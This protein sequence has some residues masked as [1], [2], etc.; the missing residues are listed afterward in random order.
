MNEKKK[1]LTLEFRASE[2]SEMSEMSENGNNM[3]GGYKKC[4]PN[5]MP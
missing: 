2:T 4:T 3:A 1:T 5:F